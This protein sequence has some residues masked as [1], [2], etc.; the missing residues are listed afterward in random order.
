MMGAALRALVATIHRDSVIDGDWFG[1]IDA[2][3]AD[4]FYA[5][6]GP[7][8]CFLDSTGTR[9]YSVFPALNRINYYTL[10]TPWDITT[11]VYQHRDGSL[12][13]TSES[14][15]TGVFIS[16]DGE[17]FYL[18]GTGT[19]QVREFALET[20]W[21]INSVGTTQ[22]ASLN[23]A[24]KESNPSSIFFSPDGT[25]LFVSGYT[26]DEVHRYDLTDPWRIATA[27]FVQST[28]F[29]SAI[30]SLNRAIF[31]GNSGLKLY[32]VGS[33]TDKVYEFTMSYPWD[34]SSLNPTPSKTLNLSAIDNV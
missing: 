23:V 21:T 11:A 15:P 3:I 8:D 30:E 22:T 31:I 33:T 6:G 28:N 20:P 17:H 29:I 7:G 4:G 12:I 26:Q 19:D 9:F 24:S 16:P 34:L 27:S 5:V 25:H 2:A 14:V 18:C 10:S 13:G 1:N 32:I